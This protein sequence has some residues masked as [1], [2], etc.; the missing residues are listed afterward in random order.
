MYGF[1]SDYRLPHHIVRP[2]ALD[3]ELGSDGPEAEVFVEIERDDTRVAPEETG[4]LGTHMVD[5]GMEKIAAVAF[6]A[7]LWGRGHPAQAK[8][9]P[10]RELTAIH[11]GRRLRVYAC[12][13][14]EPLALKRTT[15]EG[16]RVIV[17][18]V[19][20]VVRRLARA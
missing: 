11:L 6:S 19:D 1:A 12:D 10:A 5:A 15:V 17:A 3:L 8:G 14:Y 9:I 18:G 4:I 16:I 20:E 13:T 2:Y 7:Y